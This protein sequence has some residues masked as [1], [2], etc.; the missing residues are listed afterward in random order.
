VKKLIP[1]ICIICLLCASYVSAQCVEI[2]IIRHAEKGNNDP[3]D[4]DLSEKGRERA[5][6][7]SKFFKQIDFDSIYAS[8]RKRTHQTAK[9]TAQSKNLAIQTYPIGEE[10]QI[11]DGI[12]SD[13]AKKILWVGHSNSI[14]NFVGKLMKKEL[15][16]IDEENFGQFWKVDYCPKDASR[17][18]VEIFQLP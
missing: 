8:P 12:A 5:E 13:P 15:A 3:K 6:S 10:V 14:P 17:N 1:L 7:W 18:S 9:P 4:P 11:L 16:N 2:Y